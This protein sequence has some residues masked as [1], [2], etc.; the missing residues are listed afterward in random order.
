[1]GL[2]R[3]TQHFGKSMRWRI[4]TAH[5]LGECLL[6]EMPLFFRRS[7]CL[8]ASVVR[9]SG[10][11][12][13]P[14]T[15]QQL[16]QMNL[17]LPRRSGFSRETTLARVEQMPLETA[18]RSVLTGCRKTRKFRQNCHPGVCRGS[19]DFGFIDPTALDPGLAVTS[20][21]LYP[22]RGDG[23][24]FET[25]YSRETKRGIPKGGAKSAQCKDARVAKAMRCTFALPRIAAEAA[26][27]T[28][29]HFFAA[30][31]APTG[32]AL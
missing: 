15:A 32:I 12:L 20:E 3:K 5:P 26:P 17:P 6:K 9:H 8:C 28:A 29:R 1:M 27:T 19:E 18:S 25:F 30:E 10:A 21:W 4:A 13:L 23:V 24:F 11:L 14:L 16:K 7:L 22:G 2:A 31:A